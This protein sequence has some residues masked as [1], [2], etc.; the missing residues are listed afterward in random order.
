[1]PRRLMH[2]LCII[3]SL[4]ANTSHAEL[5]TFEF[6]GSVTSGDWPIGSPVT[7][8]YTFDSAAVDAN[9]NPHIGIY[10]FPHSLPTLKVNGVSFFFGRPDLVFHIEVTNNLVA[11]VYHAIIATE[12]SHPSQVAHLVLTDPTQ[13]AFSSDALPLSLAPLSKFSDGR[14]SYD[15]SDGPF[16]SE[17]FVAVIDSFTIVAEPGMLSLLLMALCLLVTVTFGRRCAL[18]AARK[19]C[20]AEV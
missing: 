16:I 6:G 8:T 19:L 12:F 2:L 3:V 17:G 7:L 5:I 14:L 1:M 10:W 11:D 15:L 20:C 18:L 9:P 4:A 13:T